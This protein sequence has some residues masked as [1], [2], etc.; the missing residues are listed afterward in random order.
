MNNWT[1]LNISIKHEKA[2]TDYNKLILAYTFTLSRATRHLT[3]YLNAQYFAIQVNRYL[4]T[5]SIKQNTNK[6]SIFQ[7]KMLQ[8]KN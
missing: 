4:E 5:P 7:E 1:D 2:A 8:K 6:S 3:R